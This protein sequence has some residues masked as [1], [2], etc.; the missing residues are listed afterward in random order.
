MI[1]ESKV[2]TNNECSTNEVQI[3]ENSKSKGTILILP[4]MGVPAKYYSTL[5]KN[6]SN[7]E[8]S[9]ATVDLRGQG[10]SSI[11]PSRRVDY[12][13]E[14]MIELDIK[15]TVDY[16]LTNGNEKSLIIL[17]HSLGGQLGSIFAAKYPDKVRGLLLIA[18]CSVYYKPYG[19]MQGLITLSMTQAFYLLSLIWGYLP[20]HKIG[21]AGRESRGEIRDWARQ[22]RYG[23]YILGKDKINMEPLLNNLQIP[24]LALG[25][26]QDKLAPTPAITHLVEKMKHH[27]S[28]SIKKI[29]NHNHFSWVKNSEEVIQTIDAW[30]TDL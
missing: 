20:G 6:I 30:I 22:C 3:V 7:L 16:L 5:A 19:L 12:G 2:I 23:K 18:Y 29:K 11:R 26:D 15:S 27:P 10:R 25:F 8:Y 13:Y 9:V 1:V 17:G 24:I 28:T 21:F 4:A 14:E